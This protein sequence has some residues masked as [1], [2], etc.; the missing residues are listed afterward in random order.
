MKR[1]SFLLLAVILPCGIANAD[2][3]Q[4]RGN[5]ADGIATGTAPAN[6][7][8]QGWKV[9]LPGR[10][11][12]GPI[13]VGDKVV[14][15][16]SSGY[17]QDRLHVLCFNAKTGKQLWERKFWATGRTQCHRKMCVATPNPASDGK[18][19]FAFYSSNDL[20]C[21]DLNGNLL[22]YRGLTHDFP[23]ASN[24]LGMSSSPVV[25][26]DTLV[27]QVESDAYSFATGINVKNGVSRW[28][29]TRPKRANWT[30]PA[31]L[32]GKN[33]NRAVLLQSSAGL[34]AVDPKTGKRLW[35]Y[36]DGASTIPSSTVSQGLVYVPSNGL[37]ALKP[38]PES[39]SPELLW[40]EGPLSPS[41][42][43]PLVYKGKTYTTNRAGVLSAA[44]A[45]T[46][47]LQWRMRM[48]G[49]FS[50]TPLA[51]EDKLYFFNEKGLAT[52]VDISGAKGKI[53]ASKD[54]KETILCTPAISDGFNLRPQRRPFV[55][56]HPVN[57]VALNLA[58][59]GAGGFVGAI[60]R[61]GISGLLQKK[62]P[63]VH[64]RR[65]S[66]GQRAGVPGDR[67]VDGRRRGPAGRVP[68]AA[69]TVSCNRHP[70]FVD[71][72]FPRSV[73]KPWS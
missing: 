73:S 26:G 10:G 65:H 55:E 67:R 54:L 5:N 18:R 56:I 11:L 62:F 58:A 23:N 47:K 6:F 61:Y 21:F 20:A 15:T 3:L 71:H 40:Q 25:V 32:P 60:L 41:V 66:C 69:S 37:T 31:I 34:E 8:K 12:S 17:R 30:S 16:A 48:K 28:K 36:K 2:W 72:V 51:A 33:G 24:S 68:G 64:T 43:S 70:R 44:D 53:V 4:F 42:A 46:G 49:P 29:K 50:S 22:W 57:G 38:N 7:D 9:K 39:P 1:V 14:L 45:K 35:N 27:V 13:V 19:I 52:I 59:V 63:P